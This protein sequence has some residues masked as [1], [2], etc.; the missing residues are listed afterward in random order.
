MA[1]NELVGDVPGYTPQLRTYYQGGECSPSCS[2]GHRVVRF[3]TFCAV[4]MAGNDGDTAAIN[5][6]Q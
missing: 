4:T 1:I 5:S 6:R 3:R 2:V